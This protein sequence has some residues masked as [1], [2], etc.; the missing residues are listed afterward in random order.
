MDV[1]QHYDQRG[2]QIF[3]SVIPVGLVS[4]LAEAARRIPAF[5]GEIRRQ[6][7]KMETNTFHPGSTLVANAVCNA[8][9]SMP[10]GLEPIRDMM[11]RLIIDRRLW[12]CLHE[13]DGSD[14]YTIHQSILSLSSADTDL[15]ID[16]WAMDTFPPGHAHSVWIPL[17]DLDRTSG[18][19]CVIPWPPGKLVTEAELG[20]SPARST[21]DRYNNYHNALVAKLEANSPDVVSGFICRGDVFVW[22]S[23]TPYCTMPSRPLR[24]ERLALQLMVRPSH[25]LCGGFGVE[26]GWQENAE[27]VSEQFSFLRVL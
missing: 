19:P 22:S 25:L 5:E 12:Q 17:Q 16:S 14:H 21:E 1:R 20:L 9:L 18:V 11:R 26:E 15:H 13:L 27:R 4:S 2:H 24:R 7:G 23:V 6:N 10:A 8:H 3:R